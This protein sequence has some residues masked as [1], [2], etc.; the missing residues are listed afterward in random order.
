MAR[1]CLTIQIHYFHPD[2]TIIEYLQ[3]ID[4]DTYFNTGTFTYSF[5]SSG[6]P[7]GTVDFQGIATHEMGHW[8]LLNDLSDAD[9]C[10]HNNQRDTMCG[11]F[12][13]EADTFFARTLTADDKTSANTVYP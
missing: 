6:P 1:T 3:I 5:S 12:Y 7:A 11:D 2:P 8:V 4:A 13:S 9:A 10:I